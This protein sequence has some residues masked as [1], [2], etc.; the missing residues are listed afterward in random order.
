MAIPIWVLLIFALWTLLTL[1]FSVGAYRMGNILRGK[2]P[3]DQYRFPDVDRSE[4][5]RRALRAHMNCV[6]NLPVYA[7]LVVVMMYTGVFTP[8]LSILAVVLMVFRVL[9]TFVHVAFRQEGKITLV[10]FS[11]F[12]VQ[13]VC[14]LWMGV[15]LMV[16]QL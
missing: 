2:S 5:H 10:R 15:Y 16:T 11:F 7:A 4:R 14:M 9:H 1:A 12:A 3:Y 8:I 13:F 6:E